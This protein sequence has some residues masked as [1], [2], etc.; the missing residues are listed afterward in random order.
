MI[1]VDG[2]SP[3]ATLSTLTVKAATASIAKSEVKFPS[4]IKL[5]EYKKGVNYTIEVIAKDIYGNERLIG[6]ADKIELTIR[7]KTSSN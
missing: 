4:N 7:N 1:S 6:Y 5:N 2:S 3:Q